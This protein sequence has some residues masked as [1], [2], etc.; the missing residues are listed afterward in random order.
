MRK[1]NPTGYRTSHKKTH[2]LVMICCILLYLIPFSRAFGNEPLAL[3]HELQEPFLGDLPAMKARH[4]IRALVTYSQ[5][6][7][8]IVKGQPYGFE[9]DLLQAY[10]KWLNRDIKKGQLRTRLVF[11]PVPFNRLLPDLV[12]GKG[13]IAASGLTITSER[14][15][16][17]RFTTPYVP[18]VEEIIVTRKNLQGLNALEDLQGKSLFMAKGT[19][20]GSHL[21]TLN[22]QFQQKS[23]K[24][25]H[26]KTPGAHL[27]TED[28]L[29]LTNSGVIDHMVADKHLAELW[30]SP[31]PH[32]QLRPDLPIHKGGKIA[33]ATRPHNPQ[34]RK[35]LNAFLKTHKKGT[36]LGN[37]LFKRYYQNVEWITNPLS[38]TEKRK[39]ATYASLFKKYGKAYQF[40]WKLLAA[41]AYQESRLDQTK[42]SPRGA[43]GLMQI[44]PST[45]YNPPVKI[46][47]IHQPENNV[48]AGVKY[49]AHLR[50]RYFSHKQ[51]PPREQIN[52]ALAA[53]N[54]GPTKLKS[55]QQHAKKM[56]LNPYVWFS[57]MEQIA[58]RHI[59][60]EPVRYVANIHKYY[61]AYRQ[62][63]KT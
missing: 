49:L 59:G 35:S 6:N 27:T 40:D 62:S 37:I 9:Y 4:V 38:G 51:Y 25:I 33:W 5:T 41:Q 55:L 13:D 32:I 15:K 7:F 58:L 22:Q 31:L 29:E 1:K 45:A 46:K 42:K 17:V 63:E 11:I 57:N 61:L 14:L 53:Y 52:F 30:S 50:D 18:N 44:L 21:Q 47:N 16:N 10:A 36:L 19:S 54:A 12:N 3:T 24:L 2:L 60:R 56:G 26:I 39:L 8:F 23:M 20:Y 34:L 48:H 43:L 28:L